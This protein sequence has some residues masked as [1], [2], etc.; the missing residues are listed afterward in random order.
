[1]RQIQIIQMS[2][3]EWKNLKD[4]PLTI[5]LPNNQELTFQVDGGRK[6]IKRTEDLRCL[7]KG[8]EDRPPFKRPQDLKQ[9]NTRMH[10]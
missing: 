10:K 5:I 1:M 9:H 7:K 2:I 4:E 3:T 8:C 6:R